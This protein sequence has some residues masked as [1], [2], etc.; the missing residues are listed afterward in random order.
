[1]VEPVIGRSPGRVRAEASVVFETTTDLVAGSIVA[2]PHYSKADEP[3]AFE[4][5]T[6]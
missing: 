1:M 4:S 2:M 3:L 6:E 5:S